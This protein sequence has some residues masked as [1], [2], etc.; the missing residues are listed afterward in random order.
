MGSSSSLRGG[1]AL[2]VALRE[3][4]DDLAAALDA[5]E[6]GLRPYITRQQRSA[7][8]KQQRFVPS[9]RPVEVLGSVVLELIRKVVHRRKTAEYAASSAPAALSGTA[10]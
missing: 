6:T 7:R 1:A 9:S 8:V 4:P 10:R 2:G 5:Y 3:H